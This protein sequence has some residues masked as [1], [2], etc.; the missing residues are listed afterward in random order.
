[1]AAFASPCYLL[2]RAAQQGQG[3]ELLEVGGAKYYP[4][5]YGKL[6]AQAGARAGARV[7]LSVGAGQVQPGAQHGLPQAGEERTQPQAKHCEV[8]RRPDAIN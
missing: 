2:L 5:S 1:M 4:G 7:M 3:E 8:S 6:C